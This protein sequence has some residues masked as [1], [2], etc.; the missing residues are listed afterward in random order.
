LPFKVVDPKFKLCGNIM[1]YTVDP[2]VTVAVVNVSVRLLLPFM[3]TVPETVPVRVAIPETGEV[4]SIV[5]V[6][7][8]VPVHFAAGHEPTVNVPNPRFDDPSKFEIVTPANDI[9]N[10]LELLKL[11]V[12]VKLTP[13]AMARLGT[14][15]ANATSRTILLVIKLPLL[16]VGAVCAP[17]NQLDL[18]KQTSK[19][20]RTAYFVSS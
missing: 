3:R 5:R 10:R 11:P 7:V 13:P 14:R 4:S 20:S 8:S 1:L 6:K 9:G 17:D 12:V 2:M 16:T 18:S 15:T 19:W